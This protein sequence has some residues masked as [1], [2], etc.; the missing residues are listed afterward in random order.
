MTN[1]IAELGEEE[2]KKLHLAAIHLISRQKA[3]SNSLELLEGLVVWLQV[4]ADSDGAVKDRRIMHSSG[5]KLHCVLFTGVRGIC[6]TT[7]R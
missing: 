5:I 1:S 3:I 4:F 6:S 2:K 7:R